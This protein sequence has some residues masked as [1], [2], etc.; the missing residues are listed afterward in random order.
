M[1]NSRNKLLF[2]SIKVYKKIERNKLQPF[3][4]GTSR[5]MCQSVRQTLGV[6]TSH[7][8]N[9]AIWHSF[10]PILPQFRLKLWALLCQSYDSIMSYFS[11]FFAWKLQVNKSLPNFFVSIKSWRSERSIKKWRAKVRELIHKREVHLGEGISMFCNTDSHSY[12]S[13][14]S[15]PVAVTTEQGKFVYLSLWHLACNYRFSKNA[16][17]VQEAKRRWHWHIAINAT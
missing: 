6:V 10:T 11:S 16:G 12:C 2:N 14:L 4:Y 13:T 17:R 3:E 1:C 5:V 9:N 7:N 15:L 8:E